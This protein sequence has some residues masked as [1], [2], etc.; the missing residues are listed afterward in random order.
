[1]RNYFY[2]LSLAAVMSMP[3]WAQQP[4]PTYGDPCPILRGDNYRLTTPIDFSHGIRCISGKYPVINEVSNEKDEIDIRLAAQTITDLRTLIGEIR[5]LRT[6]MREYQQKLAQAKAEYD[7]AI[8]TTT[9][10]QESWQAKA[11][12]DT[13][14]SVEKIPARLA[15]D[16]NLREALLASLKD[17]LPKDSDFIETLRQRTTP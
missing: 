4:A 7:T 6:E 2:A 5:G 15:L 11:L 12:N 16:K 8:K 1:M 14:E 10:S 3:V 13:L 17:E 9:A